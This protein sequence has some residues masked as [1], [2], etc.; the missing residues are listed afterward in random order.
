A[1]RAGY[2]HYFL[3]GT[4]D[5]ALAES[6]MKNLF[7]AMIELGDELGLPVSLGGGVS[8][9]DSLDDFK[10]GFATGRA[11]WY[12][13]GVICDPA[14]YPELA[15][16][17]GAAPGGLFPANRRRATHLPPPPGTLCCSLQPF[18]PTVSY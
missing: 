1:A 11:P 14:A 6:P 5:G 7:A 10:R 2:L 9:G 4:R 3:G 17:A 15:A 13:H 8:P 12:T 18:C 16:A